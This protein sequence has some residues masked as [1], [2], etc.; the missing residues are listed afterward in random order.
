[1]GLSGGKDSSGLGTLVLEGLRRLAADEPDTVPA[2]VVFQTGLTGVD[3]PAVARL[4]LRL[5]DDLTS[6]GKATG[7]DVRAATYTPPLQSVYAVK[8]LSGST[9]PCYPGSAMKCSVSWK[10]EPAGRAM[11]A[12]LPAMARELAGRTDARSVELRQRLARTNGPLVLIG[13]RRDESAARAARMDSRGEGE[14]IRETDDGRRVAAPLASMT[15]DD[16]WEVLAL[17]GTDG[18]AYPVWRPD[19]TDLVQLYREMGGNECPIVSNLDAKRTGCGAR[20]GCVTCQAVGD[21]RSLDA[22]IRDPRHAYLR[23]LSD[24]RNF[25]A[26]IRWD[27]NR[28]CWLTRT[29]RRV[30]DRS[31]VRIAPDSFNH[32]TLMQLIGAHLTAD[33]D[34]AER[35]RRFDAAL[36]AGRLP[37]ADPYVAACLRN[38]VTPDQSYLDTMRHPQ[39]RILPDRELVALDWYL[40]VMGRARRPFEVLEMA[41]RVWTEDA[42]FPIPAPV[43]VERTPM[44]APRWLEFT[45][46][47]P[48]EFPGLASPMVGAFGDLCYGDDERHATKDGRTIF[49]GETPLF[50]VDE[51]A[52]ALVLELLYPDDLRREYREPGPTGIER[53]V[54]FHLSLGAV[55]LSPQGRA[56]IHTTFQA[57]Q[58]LRWA[59]WYERSN[60][61]LYAAAVPHLPGEAS[62]VPQ[63]DVLP[64]RSR[65]QPLEQLDLFLP[66]AA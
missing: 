54:D 55:T 36:R 62:A 16:V 57:R 13:T 41:H 48:H 37:T 44:P 1:M 31:F 33:R 45:G 60:E 63:L 29:I 42:S 4:A 38:G 9:L 53:T 40:A 24:I 21:D 11:R 2:R 20:S 49:A 19:F 65:P 26:S 43:A 7:F 12:L 28:R 66:Q 50:D 46:P 34:E 25:V 22:M 52:A 18:T 17:A 58:A 47:A 5:L 27:W 15:E 6:W 32:E 3:N 10:V 23:P 56:R 59:G 35:A 61:E 30:G 8:L 14:H 64:I 51:E 39:F